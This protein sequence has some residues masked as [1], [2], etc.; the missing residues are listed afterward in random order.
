MEIAGTAAI[1]DATGVVLVQSP[2]SLAGTRLE[3]DEVVVEVAWERGVHVRGERSLVNHVTDSG[4][5]TVSLQDASVRFDRIEGD[6]LL[7]AFSDVGEMGVSTGFLDGLTLV[8]SKGEEIVS[9]G[10]TSKTVSA[11]DEPAMLGFSYTTQEPVVRG[12]MAGTVRAEGS[13]ILFVH[14]VQIDAKGA[15]ETYSDWTGYRESEPDGAVT[16][17]E[18]RVTK[19]HVRNGTFSSTADEVALFLSALDLEVDGEIASS[20]VTGRLRRADGVHIFHDDRFRLLGSGRLGLEAAPI[21][22]IPSVWLRP[23][24]GFEV[25]GASSIEGSGPGSLEPGVGPVAG[26]FSLGALALLVL[27]GMMSVGI[28]P[29]PTASVRSHQYEIWMR[30]GDQAGDRREWRRASRCYRHATRVRKDD[31]SAL[32]EWARSELEAGD[33]KASEALAMRLAALPDMDRTDALE[34]LVWTA[35]LR[36]DEAAVNVRLRRLG[37][38][39]PEVARQ[40][41]ADLGL[42]G[43]STSGPPGR[44][45]GEVLDGYA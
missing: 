40:V 21:E 26:G 39:S 3:G 24:A 2:T 12:I 37:E 43:G 20:S 41:S 35:H 25:V 31:P 17:Y 28:V 29:G 38:V 30:R 22:S 8:P 6:P 18:L 36:G 10:T 1:E 33:A 27:V 11:G 16:E 15:D 9:V 42:Q 32:F 4:R 14:D 23:A 13:F 19:I 7:L 45:G 5:D 44:L 34:L